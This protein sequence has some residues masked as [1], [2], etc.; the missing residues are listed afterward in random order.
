MLEKLK[1]WMQNAGFAA[2]QGVEKGDLRRWAHAQGLAL[3]PPSRPGDPWVFHGQGVDTGLTLEWGASQRYYIDGSE[4]RV[5]FPLKV[6]ERLQWL[7]IDRRLRRNLE[8]EVFE[9]YVEDVRTRIETR[10]PPE[11]R[12]LVMLPKVD[13]D[14]GP[15]WREG[16]DVVSN[17][18]DW[19][20]QQL[21]PEWAQT[22][23]EACRVTAQDTAGLTQASSPKASAQPLPT[24]ITIARQVM[25][26]RTRLE[27]LQEPALMAWLNWVRATR[28]STA[29]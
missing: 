25:Q 4:L 15:D 11:M 13:L 20:R 16:F 23:L 27:S 1:Q 28:K 19:T 5:R 14:W 10:T 18:P 3:A 7:A 29:G 9:E 12:W 26:M 24:V 21:G 2:Q 17:E 6:N 22:T 8:R